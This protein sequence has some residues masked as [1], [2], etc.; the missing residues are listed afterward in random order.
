MYT[1]KQ[2]KNTFL[3]FFKKNGHTIIDGA[4]IVPEN[5]PSLLFI[6]AGMAPMKKV[7]TGEEQPIAKRM[8][9]V[10]TCIRTIDIDSIGDR[11][12]LSSFYMLGSWSIG[13]YFKEGAISYAFDLLT[14]GFGIPKE[15]LYVTV[16]SGDEKRGIPADTESIEFWKKVG[17]AE[18]HIIKCGFDDNFWRMGEDP[19]PCGPCTE[20]FYD[21]GAEHGKSLEETGIFDDKNRYIEIWN[22]G[23]FMEYYQEPDKTYSKLKMRSVDTGSGLERLLMTLNGLESA[24]DTEIFTPIIDFLKQNSKTPSIESMR[25]I[26]DH[27]RT[28]VFILNAG[29]E[30]SNVKRGYVLRRLI[31]RAIRHMRRI[32]L[33]ETKIADVIKLTIDNMATVDLEPKW[34]YSKDEIVAKFMLEHSKFAKTLEQGLKAFKEYVADE[35]NI[36]N[37]KIKSELVFKLFDTFGFPLEITK[38]L[39]A[40]NGLRIDEEEFEKLFEKHREI[41]KTEG[42]FKSGLADTSEETVKLHTATHLLQAGLRHIL[43][44][45]VC[46]KGSNITPERLRFDFNFERKLTPEEIAAVEKFVNDAIAAAI[47]VVREE[48]SYDEAKNSGA[49]GLFADRYGDVISVYTI[50][51]VSKE[52]CR[53]PH[54]NN[55]S[56]LGHFRIVKEESSSSGIRRIKAIVEK[57]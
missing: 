36:E 31:R 54:V 7:F 11:H 24:Y 23:V 42:S 14:N 3:E 19:G 48:M 15:K 44:N 45:H 47:P 40:E 30:P 41:S 1:V 18:S 35:N 22:A 5:D 55:T 2:I 27:V 13:D 57:I 51:D 34:N 6:N 32:G 21:T 28:S 9:N 29:V 17:V 39:A 56:E 52:M 16:F 37:G 43:G 53:G 26:A 10:Q 25:I 4:S 20:M 38:E 50:G 33:D 12:H 46:Q 8:T 49:L